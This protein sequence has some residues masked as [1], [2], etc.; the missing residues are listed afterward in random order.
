[1]ARQRIKLQFLGAANTVT[2]SRYLLTVNSRRILIDCGMFQGYKYLRERNWRPFPV[3]PASIDAVVLTHAHMDHSGFVPALAAQGFHGKVYCTAATAALC[4]ILWQDAGHLQEEEAEYL[5]RH[6][7]SKHHPARPLYDRA[8]ARTALRLLKAVDT[9]KELR[10]GDVTVRFHPNGHILGSTFLE[11]NAAGRALL[12]SGDLGRPD[13]ILMLPPQPPTY[14]D[15]LIVE[16]TY[17]DRLH[18]AVNVEQKVADIVNATARQGG[19][20]L[21]P[22]FAVG[23]AQA[24][25]YLLRKLQEQGTIPPLPIYLD[26]PMAIS[27]T[28]LFRRFHALHKL[29]EAECELMC[30]QLH[31][32]RSV[33]QSKALNQVSMPHIIV[34]ASGMATGGRVLHHLK[35]LLGSDRNTILFAGYQSGGTRGARLVGGEKRIKIHGAYYDVNARIENLDS[36]SAHADY[37]EILRWLKQMPVAPKQ[38]FVTHGEPA[39]ADAMRLRLEETLGWPARVPDSGE[40]FSL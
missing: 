37:S 2:G 23:R 40:G 15:Y 30:G 14:A 25:M 18:E 19:T 3:K 31:Y 29:S 12:F 7:I 24:V 6:Q 27:V 16:S 34:S 21:I 10:L 4:E 17:G 38:T 28:D 33:D 5:N 26:S 9:R 13:D 20:V 8:Q 32:V 39:A 22:A 36:L 1:M 35:Y 11:V